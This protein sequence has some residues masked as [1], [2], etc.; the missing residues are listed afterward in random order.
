MF[1]GWVLSRLGG[2]ALTRNSRLFYQMKKK[3][4][5][6]LTSFSLFTSLHYGRENVLPKQTKKT[7]N[8]TI[9]ELK[10]E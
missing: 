2:K 6:K 5:C 10:I 4:K 3:K 7:Q 9:T 8:Q 1:C